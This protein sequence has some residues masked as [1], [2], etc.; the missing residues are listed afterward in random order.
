MFAAGERYLKY[1]RSAE[2]MRSMRVI[3]A[4]L[5]MTVGAREARFK[6]KRV[7]V[8]PDREKGVVDLSTVS[9]VVGRLSAVA[10][11]RLSWSVSISPV[12]AV[13]RF[14]LGLWSELSPTTVP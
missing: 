13:L 8:R 12:L 5:G 6:L 7:G 9:D 3:A 4:D 10:R 2:A 11:S 14:V 1:M